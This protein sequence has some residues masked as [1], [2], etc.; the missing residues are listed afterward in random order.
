MNLSGA[1]VAW[2]LNHLGLPVDRMV[3]LYDDLDLPFGTV[4][5]RPA[6]GAGGH[7]GMESILETLGTGDF[8]RVRIGIADPLVPKHLKVDYL[9]SPL[10][11]ERWGDLVAGAKKA[12]DAVKDAVAM[13]WGKA[14]SIHNATPKPAP[15]PG[16]T[17]DPKPKPASRPEH[18]ARPESEPDPKS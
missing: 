12:A 10:P 2:W 11:D 8:P 16:A 4:R 5:L 15:E 9:L 7:H 14:M 1:P 13:G 17:E 18:P 6:G 3:V